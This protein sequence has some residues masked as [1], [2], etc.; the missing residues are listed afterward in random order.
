MEYATLRERTNNKGDL[1]TAITVQ[2]LSTAG[3]SDRSFSK[4]KILPT[5]SE[6]HYV[7]SW[8]NL[9]AMIPKSVA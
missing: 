5:L 1:L 6:P 9:M 7:S 4:N 3:E 2:R 8:G